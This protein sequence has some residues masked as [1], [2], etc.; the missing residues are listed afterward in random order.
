MKKGTLKLLPTSALFIICLDCP[1]NVDVLS[2]RP[3]TGP[4]AVP[5]GIRDEHR[6]WRDDD[7]RQPR[8]ARE[9]YRGQDREKL[10]DDRDGRDRYRPRSAERGGRGRDYEDRSRF[11]RDEIHKETLRERRRS[12]S[13]SVGPRNDVDEKRRRVG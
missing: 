6:S 5:T 7:G 9:S 3:G 13:R 11:P 10:R 12:R 4:N 8:Q 1:Q 2:G